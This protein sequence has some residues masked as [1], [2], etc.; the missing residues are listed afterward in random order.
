MTVKV[1]IDLER[2]FTVSADAESVFALLSDVPASAAHFPKVQALTPLAAGTYRWEME[3]VPIGIHSIQ[4]T[5]ACEYLADP[6]EKT[7]TWVPVKGEG[8]AVVS[9]KWQLSDL[10]GET[11]ILFSTEAELRLP[12]PGLLS[13]AIAP[14]AKLEFTNMVD[15][16][17]AN[18]KKVFA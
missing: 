8:N 12:L 1:N 5:Y 7:V 17:L 16:Y 3:Q 14:M 18:I 9:G 13:L 4:T 10:D 6:A 2:E 15:S 11:Q